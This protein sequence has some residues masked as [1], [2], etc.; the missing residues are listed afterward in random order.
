MAGRYSSLDTMSS[1]KSRYE[2]KI[3]AERQRQTPATDRRGNR[4]IREQ[5]GPARTIFRRSPVGRV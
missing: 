3:R 5:V 2:M 1:E 4:G